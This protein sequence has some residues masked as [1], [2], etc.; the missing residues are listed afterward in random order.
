VTPELL[1]GLIGAGGA[2]LGGLAT[3]AGVVYQQH[4]QAKQVAGEQQSEF[5]RQAIDTILTQT[6]ELRRLAWAKV[7]EGKFVWT[8]DMSECV[9]ATLMASLR[10]PDKELREIIEASC[11]I[12]FGAVSTSTLREIPSTDPPPVRIMVTTQQVHEQLVAY[13]R[14]EPRGPIMG[15]LGKHLERKRKL[16]QQFQEDIRALSTRRP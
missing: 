9:D 16:D 15:P 5:A 12:H 3:F 1:N 6:T 7:R 4:R 11:R 8:L 2:L 13:L 14:G 10:I